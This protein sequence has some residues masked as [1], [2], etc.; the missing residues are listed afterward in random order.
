[1]TDA[2]TTFQTRLPEIEHLAGIH[3]RRLDPEARQEAVQNTLVL[4]WRYFIRLVELGK[5]DQEHVFTSMIWWA[6]KHTKQGRQGGGSGRAKCVLDYARRRKNDVAVHDG[7]DLGSFIGLT[8]TIPDTVAFRLDVTA[9]L[10]TL[11]E[12]DRGI[13]LSLS[14]GKGTTEVAREYGVTPGAISQF[15]TRFRKKYDEFHASI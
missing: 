12:R 4:A 2:R 15:R 9:F 11:P 7:F 8:A 14:R 13:A 5:Q 6:C 3:F 10:A 1:M